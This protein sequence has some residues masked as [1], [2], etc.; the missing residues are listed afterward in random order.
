M[1]LCNRQSCH[2]QSKDKIQL[3]YQRLQ[4]HWIQA[5]HK[6][7][8]HLQP[9]IW[10]LGSI[11][12]IKY[13]ATKAYLSFMALGNFSFWNSF[14]ASFKDDI[15]CLKTQRPDLLAIKN[16]NNSTSIQEALPFRLRLGF[17]QPNSHLILTGIG[18]LDALGRIWNLSFINTCQN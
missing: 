8:P 14:C 4:L 11:G 17:H 13:A 10:F 18:H 1:P 7:I 2:V 3:Q 15:M 5:H 6:R 16:I 9:G 12:C